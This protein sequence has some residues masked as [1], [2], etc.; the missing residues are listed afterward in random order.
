[1]ADNYNFDEPAPKPPRRSLPVT[2]VVSILFL[3]M[4]VCLAGYF[5]L[6]FINPY[7]A[8]NPLQPPA[9]ESL[10]TPTATVTPILP[11]TWTSTATI[12]PTAT[13]TIAPSWTPEATYTPFSLVPPTKTP[14]PSATPK[15]IYP[16]TGT[17][18]AIESTI[19]HPENGCAWLGVGGEATDMNNSPVLYLVVRMGGTLNGKI[20]D[21]NMFTVVTGIA[22]QYGRAGFEFPPLG[23]APVASEKNALWVQLLDQAGLPLSDKVYFSTYNDCKKNLIL[24][25]F[26]KVK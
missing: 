8:L 10:K 5:L 26:K 12:Q 22:P 14:Q 3:L 19:I 20:L 16:F 2:D 15:S 6:V 13:I 24:V 21:P 11:P 1:M 17:V 7:S 4:A 25:R 18:T 9:G 23:I